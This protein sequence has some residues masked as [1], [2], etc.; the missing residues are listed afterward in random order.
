MNRRAEGLAA[1]Q[2]APRLRISR[3]ARILA[4]TAAVWA[5]VA[6]LSST[7]NA[8]LIAV[9]ASF[10]I[11][12]SHLAGRCGMSHVGALTPPGKVSGRRLR[13]LGNVLVYVTAGTLA[14]GAVGTALGLAGG[15]LVPSQLQGVA[16]VAVICL[17]LVGLASDLR[18]ISWRLPQPNRQTRREWSQ[19][20]RAPIP[21]ALWGLGL[22]V[23]VATVFTFSGTW[24]VLTLPV[25][26]GEPAFGA[27]LLTVH[28]LGRVTSVLA[29]PLLLDDPAN[30]PDLLVDIAEARTLFRITNI[31]GIGLMCLASVLLLTGAGT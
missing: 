22:G 7:R 11:G 20:Y 31:V 27:V 28:W 21:A 30:T 1:L 24:L 6:A 9:A 3:P 13:W 17:G 18:L 8:L 2:A 26:H 19:K 14:A 23:T 10:A 25:A 12:W 4:A 15:L 16:I 29:G 5:V